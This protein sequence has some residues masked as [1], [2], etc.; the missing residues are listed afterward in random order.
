MVFQRFGLLPH[1]TVLE[2][3]AFGLEMQGINARRR[4]QRAREV[5]KIVGL[6]GWEDHYPSQLSGG[7]QQRVGLARALAADPEILLMD[8]PF[9]ALDPLIRREMQEELLR[10]QAQ[11]QKTII[12][13]THDL[14]E[15]LK[16]GTRIAIMRDGAIVQMGTPE[17]IVMTPAEAY[18]SEFTKDVRKASVL[19]IRAIM[20][21]V[22]AK[23]Y[24]WQGPRVALH[25]MHE[26]EEETAFVVD[27][28]ETLQGIVRW[29]DIAQ[30]AQAECKSIQT[31]VQPAPMT[32][33]EDAPVE[34]LLPN[35]L[36]YDHPIPVVNTQ[37]E[38][39]GGVH[40]SA[41]RNLAFTASSAAQR[42]Q[43]AV[44]AK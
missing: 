5:L 35:I 18:I 21:P 22:K 44:A 6:E 41:V 15:A 42:G 28:S 43:S 36:D 7:M 23:V 30:A 31:A 24:S 33:R 16:L 14:D 34:S 2:N 37:G 3:V 38:L 4:L 27:A 8:E 13:I 25:E 17:E 26:A 39:V 20:Q 32:A 9:S 19:P 10:L 29:A 12:F 11:F 1:R 40:R